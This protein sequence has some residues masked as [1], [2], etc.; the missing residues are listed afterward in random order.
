MYCGYCGRLSHRCACGAP[1]SDIRRF[2]ARAGRRYAPLILA[3]PP[4]WAVPPQIKRRERATLQRHSRDWFRR[5]AADGGERCANC[6]AGEKLV[7]DH[8]IPI[9]RGGLSRLE[10]LQLLCAECNRI[11]GKLM[12]DCRA[13]TR[14]E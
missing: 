8:V 6:G 3:R 2:F 12:I 1:E 13:V 4:K 10:N 11:K 5:L 14:R 7:L 9:A